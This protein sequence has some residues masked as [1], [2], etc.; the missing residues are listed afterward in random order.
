M[1]IELSIHL[2]Y[3]LSKGGQN[4]CLLFPE[5]KAVLGRDF[6]GDLDGSGRS[7]ILFLLRN[8]LVPSRQLTQCHCTLHLCGSLRHKRL[9]L[10]HSYC[11]RVKDVDEGL[12]L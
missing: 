9:E 10:W 12:A 7:L 5:S 11:V 6:S 8:N 2:N 1:N 3:S 4:D